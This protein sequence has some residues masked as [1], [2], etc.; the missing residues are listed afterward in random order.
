MFLVVF[1]VLFFSILG[2]AQTRSQRLSLTEGLRDLDFSQVRRLL[3]ERRETPEQRAAKRA[4]PIPQLNKRY[5]NH[6]RKNPNSCESTYWG[7]FTDGTNR[8][9]ILQGDGVNYDESYN[10]TDP[11]INSRTGTND[12]Y[13]KLQTENLNLLANVRKIVEEL[14]PQDP[15]FYS[16]R[17]INEERKS[18]MENL[19]FELTAEGGDGAFVGLIDQDQE[20]LGKDIIGTTSDGLPIFKRNYKTEFLGD[21]PPYMGFGTN[22]AARMQSKAARAFLMGHELGHVV[23]AVPKELAQCLAR[24]QALGININYT[25]FSDSTRS[26]QA[27]ASN[28]F[29]YGRGTEL[30]KEFDDLLREGRRDDALLLFKEL[31]KKGKLKSQAAEAVSDYVGIISA[32]DFIK[33]NYATPEARRNA[34]LAV[35]FAHPPHLWGSD[36]DEAIMDKV[37]SKMTNQKRV[38]RGMLANSEFRSLVGCQFENPFDEPMDCSKPSFTQ[39]LRQGFPR[40]RKAFSGGR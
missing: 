15:N 35:M 11:Q 24:P 13:Q 4:R 27:P 31:R 37:G 9:T 7:L 14:L 33:K 23:D 16:L 18:R 12:V 8:K 26:T 25:K 22:Y 32:V 40:L 34:A 20:A 21:P 39:D 28:K 17:A 6:A 3:L 30:V 10:N 1:V 29:Y 36:A 38:L 5:K 2:H 19:Y